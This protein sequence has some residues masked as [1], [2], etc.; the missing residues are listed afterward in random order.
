MAWHGCQTAQVSEMPIPRPGQARPGNVMNGNDYITN[1]TPG[2]ARESCTHLISTNLIT[3]VQHSPTSPTSFLFQSQPSPEPFSRCACSEI[4]HARR[5]AQT[6]FAR[7]LPHRFTRQRRQGSRR[8]S[9]SLTLPAL[10]L[11]TQGTSARLFPKAAIPKMPSQ[12][13]LRAKL[14]L[15]LLPSGRNGCS[16]GRCGPFPSPPG[17]ILR[18]PR[19]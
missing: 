6:L 9:Q 12:T 10:A 18:C 15:L 17:Q 1:M 8:L 5:Q 14:L 7:N 4:H 3:H 16:S 11:N 2:L 13:V 19:G